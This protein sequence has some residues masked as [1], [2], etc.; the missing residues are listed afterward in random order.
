MSNAARNLSDAEVRA[1]TER[2]AARVPRDAS[3][4]AP[5]SRVVDIARR[6]RPLGLAPIIDDEPE[7]N[8]AGNGAD[9]RST[10]WEGKS[11]QDLACAHSVRGAIEKF[12]ALAGMMLE[13]HNAGVDETNKL[14]DGE[15]AAR[16]EIAALKEAL[17]ELRKELAA[18][19]LHVARLRRAAAERQRAKITRP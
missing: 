19:A 18:M 12:D 16:T 8:V 13:L 3:A 2:L 5:P 6:R 9:F 4:I 17:A 15:N 7:R 10:L 1:L 14:I 11:E